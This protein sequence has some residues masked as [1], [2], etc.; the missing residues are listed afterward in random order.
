MAL[1]WPM[2]VYATRLVTLFSLALS[3]IVVRLVAAVVAVRSPA[4]ERAS[5]LDMLR[6]TAMAQPNR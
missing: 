5:P 1:N 3:V 4:A 6:G 2:P